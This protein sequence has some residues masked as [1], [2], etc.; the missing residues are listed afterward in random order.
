[1]TRRCGACGAD[2]VLRSR[3]IRHDEDG[4]SASS[5]AEIWWDCACGRSI[6]EYSATTSASVSFTVEDERE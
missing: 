1:M 2:M 4:V 3:D 5:S 6:M